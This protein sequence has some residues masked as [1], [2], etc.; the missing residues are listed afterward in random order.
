MPRDWVAWHADYEVDT[1]LARRLA[2]VQEQVERAF[3]ERGGG[4]IRILSLCSGEGRDLIV[5]LS[6]RAPAANVR[7]RLVELDR[8]LAARA[9]EGL[10][11]A[12]ILG[13]EVIEG[14]AGATTS[15]A[16]AVPADLLLLCGIFGNVSDEDIERTVRTAPTLC[17]PEATVIWTRHRRPP[18]LTPAIRRWFAASGFRHEAFVRVPDSTGSVG[19]E[20][21]VGSPQPFDPGIRLFEF[22]DAAGT[23]S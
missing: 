15:L 19:V 10:A 21:F 8:V 1:P 7:G 16:G 6:R 18:D 12:R 3:V 5:P 20:R 22:T 13:L 4:P 11:A 23:P 14:D 9:R 2:I 17:A